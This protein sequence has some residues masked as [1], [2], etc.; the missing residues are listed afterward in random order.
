M[1][2]LFT[3]VALSLA[4]GI[5]SSAYCFD[6]S[7]T[8][9]PSKKETVKSGKVQISPVLLSA[10]AKMKL[11]TNIEMVSFSD[12]GMRLSSI[13]GKLSTPISGDLEN[14]AKSYL[15]D[16]SVIFNLPSKK[17][18]DLKTI[19]TEEMNGLNSVTFEMYF[20]KYP[21]RDAQIQVNIGK[22]K[23]VQ[24]VNGSFPTVNEITN[25]IAISQEEAISAAKKAIGTADQRSEI[26]SKLV[27][28]PK[29]DGS[30]VMAYQMMIPSEKPLGDFEVLVNA[31]NGEVLWQ[32][33]QMAFENATLASPTVTGLG[34][35]F[36][37]HP[38]VASATNVPLHHLTT[39]TLEGLYAKVVNEDTA[40]S[41]SE[42]Y[43]HVYDP[44]NTHFDESNIYFYITNV[45]DFFKNLG[46]NK[47]DKPLKAVVHY[48]TKYDNAYFSPQT[49]SM[50]FGDGNKLND[51]A[52]EES[53]CYHE[54]SHAHV[55]Q[56]V[57]LNYSK[58]SGAINEGQ[59][60]YFGC[61]LSNDPILGEYAVQKMGK[62]W[63]RNL[64]D[65]LHYP[66]DIQ[67]EVHA[68]GRIWGVV[69]WDLRLALGAEK[70]DKIIEQSFYSLKAGSPKFIDGYNAI[71]VA[72]KTLFNSENTPVIT[73]VFQKRGI[74]PASYNGT[75]LTGK[76]LDVIGKFNA[77][78][79]EN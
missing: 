37:N 72:D 79:A 8:Q 23:T 1:R 24:L 17:S 31:E 63:L 3:S 47:L 22:D 33:N 19:E 7:P 55:Q 73:Q 42:T 60:D 54:Y 65:N 5:T 49:N 6:F 30:A 57:V 18:S 64:T 76:D 52:K 67:G 15:I 51:L 50:A 77:V 70:S 62:P 56:I 44:D 10:L 39:K 43:E 48:G 34:S 71:L 2:K 16:N 12:D 61:S 20:D 66:E 40:G 45:H 36:V 29:E 14:G 69:L 32:L 13:R 38:L 78:H 68:D 11:A 25:S 53:V 26:S 35:V 58:E 46:Y 74:A 75:V 9:T 21:V 4:L 27:V 41:I 59:A 28:F